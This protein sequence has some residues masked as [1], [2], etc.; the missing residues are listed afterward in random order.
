AGH[1]RWTNVKRKP[2]RPLKGR[3][4]KVISVSVERTLL[5]RSDAVA[6]RMGVA[7]AGLIER[8]PSANPSGWHEVARLLA[9]DAEHGEFGF[10]VAASTGRVLVGAPHGSA[11]HIFSLGR[12]RDRGTPIGASGAGVDFPLS[13][14]PI[15]NVPGLCPSDSIPT[16]S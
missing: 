5:A 16:Y 3:G 12:P 6:R 15:P 9:C 4:V 1:R 11:Q 8:G 10:S 13:S 7:R 2:E 14:Q